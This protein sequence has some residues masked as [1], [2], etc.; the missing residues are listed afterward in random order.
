MSLGFGIFLEY[1]IEDNGRGID[2]SKKSE[3][4]SKTLRE[5]MGMSRGPVLNSIRKLE[6]YEG[7]HG[8]LNSKEEYEIESGARSLK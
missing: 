3:G 6:K 8:G 2:K 4:Q 5:T 1:H 7:I